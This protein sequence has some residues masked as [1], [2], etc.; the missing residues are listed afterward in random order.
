MEIEVDSVLDSIH[1]YTLKHLAKGSVSPLIGCYLNDGLKQMRLRPR[2]T[3]FLLLL[4]YVHGDEDDRFCSPVLG[5]V[6]CG[7]SLRPCL[8]FLMLNDFSVWAKLG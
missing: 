4:K 3:R 5:P 1:T 8:T 2:W 6:G 7:F